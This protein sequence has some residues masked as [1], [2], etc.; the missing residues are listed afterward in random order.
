MKC[1]VT[2]LLLM[3]RS[4][5]NIKAEAADHMVINTT[6]EIDRQFLSG[7]NLPALRTRLKLATGL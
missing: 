6:F 7:A 3:F 5:K 4:M 2:T 1:V